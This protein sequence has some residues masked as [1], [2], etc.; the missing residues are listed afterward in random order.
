MK[1]GFGKKAIASYFR[2][3]MLMTK[4]TKRTKGQLSK[5]KAA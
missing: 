1:N 4:H 2:A 3:A 5:G